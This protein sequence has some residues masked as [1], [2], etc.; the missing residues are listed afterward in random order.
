ML[1]EINP[2]F[3]SGSVGKL[4]NVL[5]SSIVFLEDNWERPSRT[6]RMKL[7]ITFWYPNCLVCVVYDPFEN[8]SGA[9]T[10]VTL[11]FIHLT[12]LTFSL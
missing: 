7:H 10:K 5:Y 3:S 8:A 2:K 12:M 6:L 4:T 11:H 1:L 9:G